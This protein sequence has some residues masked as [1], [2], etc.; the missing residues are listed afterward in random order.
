[1][2]NPIKVSEDLKSS[3]AVSPEL[4]YNSSNKE[5]VVVWSFTGSSG[6]DLAL[7]RFSSTGNLIGDNL[8]IPE[9]GNFINAPDITYNN[10]GNQYLVSF[11][12]NAPDSNQG[13]FGQLLSANGVPIGNNLFINNARFEPSFLYN[14][15]Q[16]E[17]FQTSRRFPGG[18]AIFGQRID[19]NGTLI[20]SV[21]RI[22][23]TGDSAPNGE[24]AFNNIDNQYLATWRDQSAS[25]TDV[26]GRLISADGSFVSGQ[27]DIAEGTG[28]A[29]SINTAFDS[30]NTQFLVA[31]GVPDEGD[32]RAQLVDADGTAI[33][34]EIV[35]IDNGFNTRGNDAIS[36]AFSEDLGIY[37]LAAATNSGLLGQFI[38]KDGSL[39]DDAFVI[40]PRSDIFQNSA[41]YNPDESQF[42]VSWNF[43]FSNEG[44][45]V[46]LISP[47]E[48]FINGTSGNDFLTGT[49]QSDR[50]NGLNGNDIIIGKNGNDTLNGGN[51]RDRLFGKDGNDSLLGG[52]GR[53]F[54]IGGIGDDFLDGGKNN[55][56]L[57][58]GKGND[59]FVLRKGDGLDT[60]FDYQDGTDSFLLAE[61][62]VF[63]DLMIA[64]NFG[65]TTISLTQTSEDLATLVNVDASDIGVEDFFTL[66]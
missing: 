10:R 19:S 46:Q 33:G 65:R 25:G 48:N 57:F 62:L 17:Y 36:V 15:N 21:I 7:Q 13:L 9:N 4:A 41:V 45:F 49:P 35:V 1:M 32:V 37:L 61:S 39:I 55:D 28:L 20:N 12:N 34:N 14:L 47:P 27:F 60:I 24:V 40:S 42:A 53:D 52:N 2:E 26:V 38:S 44:I 8:Q 66:V 54:L 63:E 22:D 16:N 11:W 64:Q 50:L 56:L 59:Q 29:F 51:G 18:N 6:S 3:F 23:S 30:T 5:Y 43:N 31:Y 58:G